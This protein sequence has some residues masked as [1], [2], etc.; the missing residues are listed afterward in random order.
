L[1]IAFGTFRE[2]MGRRTGVSAL[3]NP[4]GAH[5]DV[6]WRGT[7]GCVFR[8]YPPAPVKKSLIGVCALALLG[9]TISSS[10]G[11]ARSEIPLP[12]AARLFSCLRPGP[13]QQGVSYVKVSAV[14]IRNIMSLR[15][16]LPRRRSWPYRGWP[17]AGFHAGANFA[18]WGFCEVRIHG[19]LRSSFYPRPRNACRNDWETVLL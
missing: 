19:V 10:L 2:T 17:D 12:R 3:R 18:L 4:G 7:S 13:L 9:S 6:N 14:Y 8:A 1:C 11:R 16:P 15:G 5:P